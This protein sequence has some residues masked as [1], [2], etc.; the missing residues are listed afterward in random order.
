LRLAHVTLRFDAPGGVETTVRKVTAGL[1]AAGEDVQVFA[2]D[3]F[4]ESGWVR[5]ADYPP[6][7]EG[8]PVHRFPVY[9]R[10]IPGLTLPLMTGLVRALDAAH[11]QVIHAHSHRYGHVMEA[12]AVARARD[13]PLVV[14]TH[15]H[16]ADRGEPR[17]KKGLLRVQDFGFGATA[18]RVAGA[19]VV[20]TALEARL[21]SEFAPGNRVRIIPPGVDLEGWRREPPVVRPRALPARY[22]L[23][24]GRVAPNK[25]LEHLI[26][27][28]SLLPAPERIPLVIL[29]R[30][31][32]EQ[33]AL[34]SLARSLGVVDSVVW[35]G[36]VAD[37]PE[38]RAIYRGAAIFIL[39][40]EWEA[41]GLV[42]LEAMAAE[43]PIIASSVGGVPEVL[44]GGQDGMLVPYGDPAA[45]A[46]AIRTLIAD[47]SRARS[48]VR[49]GTKRVE[50]LTWDSAVQRHLSLYRELAG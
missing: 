6:V 33:T 22:L 15:Y 36:H 47:P 16:P 20:E 39:P 1:K 8:V 31:W 7:V 38:F 40:S 19:L 21:V 45:I 11:P 23:Y 5:R 43:V 27:A 49:A 25:G 35:L 46:E 26:G 44:E 4:D 12:A 30:D 14:S 28:L 29:G 32:G 48:L 42:L 10:L 34:E 24:A 3:L 37:E 41:F 17:L 50:G 9:K 2:S 18:Y 13:V